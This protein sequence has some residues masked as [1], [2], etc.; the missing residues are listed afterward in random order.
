[1]GKWTASETRPGYI[2]KTI[3]CGAA[4]ITISRPRLSEA[5]AAKAE[6]KARTALEGV[7]RHYITATR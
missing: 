2:E 3:K 7:M 4:T 5:E 1:M 6:Q